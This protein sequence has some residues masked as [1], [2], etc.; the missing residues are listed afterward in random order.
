VVPEEKL[1][2]TEKEDLWAKEEREAAE[3]QKGHSVVPERK[4]KLDSEVKKEREAAEALKVVKEDEER[5]DMDGN[6]SKSPTGRLK[7]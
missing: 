2:I 4:E 7:N 3:D 1:A 6:S 5:P